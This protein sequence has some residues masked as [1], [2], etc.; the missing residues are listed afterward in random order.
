MLGLHYR[1]TQCVCDAGSGV[2]ISF[3]VCRRMIHDEMPRSPWWT[4]SSFQEAVIWCWSNRDFICPVHEDSCTSVCPEGFCGAILKTWQL[5]LRKFAVNKHFSIWKPSS[6]CEMP[7]I[8]S[9]HYHLIKPL[10]FRISE[11]KRAVGH[12]LLLFLVS[13]DWK[14]HTG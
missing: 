11:Y 12:V 14:E 10:L 13:Q 1:L 6:A 5:L 8:I 7:L 4:Q 3:C 9:E 2:C